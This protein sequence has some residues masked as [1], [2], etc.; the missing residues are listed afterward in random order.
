MDYLC[1][2]VSRVSY[3]RGFMRIVYFY[4][5]LRKMITNKICIIIAIIMEKIVQN[6]KQSINFIL[7]D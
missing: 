4:V 3:G 1:R 6:N 2:F 7:F 5:T